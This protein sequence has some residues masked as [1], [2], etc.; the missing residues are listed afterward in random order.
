M[1][2]QPV[3]YFT[4]HVLLPITCQAFEARYNTY[5]TGVKE[6]VIPKFIFKGK[7][8]KLLEVQNRDD[9]IYFI[10]EEQELK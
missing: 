9:G 8:I 1:K 3:K 5:N 10:V 2:F 6:I 4:E 7:D